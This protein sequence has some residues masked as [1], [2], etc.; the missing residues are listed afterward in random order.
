MTPEGLCTR[1]SATVVCAEHAVPSRGGRAADEG[2]TP[3]EVIDILEG[4]DCGMDPRGYCGKA[5]SEE[6]EMECPYGRVKRN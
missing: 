3:D 2:G 5:G 6:C 4:D 1:C